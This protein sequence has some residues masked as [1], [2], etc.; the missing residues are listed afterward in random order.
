MD[1]QRGKVLGTE[2]DKS[3]WAKMLRQPIVTLP[4]GVD[5]AKTPN[6][7]AKSAEI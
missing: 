6:E 7:L 4:L 3:N 1:R 5:A 2:T